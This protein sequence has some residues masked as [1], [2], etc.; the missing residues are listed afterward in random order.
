MCLQTYKQQIFLSDKL[1]AAKN[2]RQALDAV[3][4]KW[5]KMNQIVHSQVNT[6]GT[7]RH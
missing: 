1:T 3:M 7:V 5:N 6:T 2:L 4:C